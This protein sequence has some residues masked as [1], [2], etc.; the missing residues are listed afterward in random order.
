[1][2]GEGTPSELKIFLGWLLDSRLFLTQL[3]RYK[4]NAWIKE[5]TDLLGSRIPFS[6][7]DVESLI[8]KLNHAG[9]IIPSSRHFLNRIR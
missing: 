1:M 8:G 9:F 5:I 6:S 7:N 4:G 2:E 3:P